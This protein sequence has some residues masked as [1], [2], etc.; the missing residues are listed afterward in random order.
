MNWAWTIQGTF[1]SL[2]VENAA[3]TSALFYRGLAS[4]LCRHKI[5]KMGTKNAIFY[6][7]ANHQTV[8]LVRSCT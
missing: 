3:V 6:F 7:L 8:E 5:G 1:R 2:Q 4:P